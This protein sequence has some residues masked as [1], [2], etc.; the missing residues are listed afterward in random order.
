MPPIPVVHVAVSDEAV[1]LPAEDIPGFAY[2]I[3][4]AMVKQHDRIVNVPDG[5]FSAG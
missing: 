2:V 4:I 5:L 1:A 3:T